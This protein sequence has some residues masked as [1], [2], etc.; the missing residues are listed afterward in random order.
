MTRVK[1]TKRTRPSPDFILKPS[2]GRMYF[3]YMLLFLSVYLVSFG[4]RSLNDPQT[5]N[6]EY[7]IANW[8]LDVLLI[9]GAPL[10]LA[11]FYRG[12]WTLRVVDGERIEGSAG[13]FAQRVEL[14]IREINWEATRRSFSSRLK[15]ANSLT[16]GNRRILI[17]IWFYAPE[18][19]AEFLSAIGYDR[20]ISRMHS[21][22]K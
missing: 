6:L 12:R 5:F 17:N 22:G 4:L 11:L 15:L 2:L 13:A 16:A 19:F 20:A 3:I 8:Q 9:F 10:L 21:A 7:L 1:V 14:P 18:A